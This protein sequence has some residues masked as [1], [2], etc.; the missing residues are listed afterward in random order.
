MLSMLPVSVVDC[1]FEPR[2]DK[3]KDD[4]IGICCFSTKFAALT[5]KSRDWLVR[6]QDNVSEWGNM[7]FQ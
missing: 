4:T 7:L 1:G 3:T 2:S 6:N 5:K